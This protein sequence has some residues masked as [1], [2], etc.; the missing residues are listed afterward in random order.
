MSSLELSSLVQAL[1]EID[2]GEKI[3]ELLESAENARSSRNLEDASKLIK[4]ALDQS[5]EF[6]PGGSKDQLLVQLDGT[7]EKIEALLDSD[8][9]LESALD[10]LVMRSQLLLMSAELNMDSGSFAAAMSELDE[11]QSISEKLSDEVAAARCI[12]TRGMLLLMRRE[13]HAAEEALLRAVALCKSAGDMQEEVETLKLLLRLHRDRPKMFDRCCE[14]YHQ[15]LEALQA[16]GNMLEVN[17]TLLELGQF[18]L[19]KHLADTEGGSE[20]EFAELEMTDLD[21][22]GALSFFEGE[23][24][25]NEDCLAEALIATGTVKMLLGDQAASIDALE[26]A[27]AL[28]ERQGDED[29]ERRASDLLHQVR[30]IMDKVD[31]TSVT[32]VS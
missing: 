8:V 23:E 15:M 20:L 30:K 5:L 13:I 22:Q 19:K 16:A 21:L 7:Q 9:T 18:R 10:I 32:P 4:Q 24:S 17:K 28:Y 11:A 29:G 3:S 6:F 2:E 1:Q 25:D 27:R 12:R 14:L 26:R 31:S